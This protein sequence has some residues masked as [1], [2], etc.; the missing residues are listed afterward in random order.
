MTT[1]ARLPRTPAPRPATLAPT[2]RGP[3]AGFVLYVSLPEGDGEDG[4]PRASAADIAETADLLREL[5]SEALPGAETSAALSLVPGTTG[6]VRSIGER[7]SHLRLLEPVE[8][9]APGTP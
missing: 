4:E 5:A 9:D 2:P 3:R 1:P 7:I 8:D 6:D